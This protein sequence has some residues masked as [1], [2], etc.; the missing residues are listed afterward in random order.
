MKPILYISPLPPP[1]GGIATWTQKIVHYGLPSGQPFIVIDSKIKGK[2][3]IFDASTFSPIELWRNFI[4]IFS[5]L[6]QI[7][8]HRPC[9]VHINSSLSKT[10][11]MRDLLTA[12][13]AYLFRI[14]VIVHYHGNLPDYQQDYFYGLSGYA[15]NALM[16]I[17]HMNIVT[18][19]ASLKYAQMHFNQQTK[20][21]IQLILLP[22][23]IEDHIFAHKIAKETSEQLRAIFIGGM[24]RKKG[25]L[26]LIHAAYAYP[27]IEFH[28]FGKMHAD[29]E[30][31]TLPANM[32]L[33]G[34]VDHDL[35]LKTMCHYD[36]MV[37]PSHTEGFPL[38]VL[39]AM[40]LGLPV[41]A[42]SVGA[43]PEMIDDGKG[44]FLCPAENSQALCD[45]IHALI[46]QPALLT[47]MGDYNRYKCFQSYRYSKVIK[48]FMQ[49]YHSIAEIEPCAE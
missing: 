16:R 18:N 12:F 20:R 23:F 27:E 7:I 29:M 11:I 40:A 24:T 28:V 30:K 36:F 14:P 21:K 44:G 31:S 13:I 6:Y 38:S 26:E 35:L 47:N 25:G 2:R 3:N 5:V 43:I 33:H 45:A 15:L 39:E 9:L 46:K 4:I 49:L 1:F 19:E 37:F 41:I 22:N 32:I 10:G 17:A 8:M 34:E 42:S 48:D